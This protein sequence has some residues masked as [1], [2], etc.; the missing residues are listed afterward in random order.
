MFDFLLQHSIIYDCITHVHYSILWTG[1]VELLHAFA[2][3]EVLTG[4]TEIQIFWDVTQRMFGEFFLD[5]LTIGIWTK[6]CS[7]MSVHSYKRRLRNIPEQRRRRLHRGKSPRPQ[8]SK[9]PLFS[10]GL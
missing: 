5:W 7:E 1:Y 4:V 3:L 2:T 10:P 6:S 9:Q 8:C